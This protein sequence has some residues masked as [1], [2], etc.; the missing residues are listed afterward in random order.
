MD[1]LRAVADDEPRAARVLED[2][3]FQSRFLEVG[4]F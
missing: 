2:I 4:C 1:S 3:A